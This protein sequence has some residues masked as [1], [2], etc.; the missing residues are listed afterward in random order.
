MLS[1]FVLDEIYGSVVEDDSPWVWFGLADDLPRGPPRRT[2]GQR[3]GFGWTPT[4]GRSL[5]ADGPGSLRWTAATLSADNDPDGQPTADVVQH[6]VLLPSTIGGLETGK[7]GS[8]VVHLRPTT[9]RSATAFVIDGFVMD[10]HVDPQL[11]ALV[12]Q[13]HE[14]R[15]RWPDDGS[16]LVAHYRRVEVMSGR[17]GA[18]GQ[19][20]ATRPNCRRPRVGHGADQ[21]TA[22]RDETGRGHLPG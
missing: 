12:G 6:P 9:R 19:D 10:N 13:R 8:N 17:R 15:H 5:I 11:I 1:R 22:D 14:D 2:F 4:N 7:Y 16:P 20:C 3:P 21:Q 18:K